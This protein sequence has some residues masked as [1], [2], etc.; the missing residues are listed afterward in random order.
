MPVVIGAEVEPE[1]SVPSYGSWWDV[2]V[3]EVSDSA[4]VREA[5]REYVENL[6]K[7]RAFV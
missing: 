1:P 7:E 3:A 2:P 6:R 5:R 4:D